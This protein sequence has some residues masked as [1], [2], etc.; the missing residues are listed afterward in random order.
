MNSDLF[1]IYYIVKVF[2]HK[3]KCAKATLEPDPIN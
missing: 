3:L 1:S 2:S